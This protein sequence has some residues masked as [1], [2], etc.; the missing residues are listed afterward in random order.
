VTAILER[1]EKAIQ[2]L[3]TM[4]HEMGSLQ[5]W[6]QRF[7]DAIKECETLGAMLTDEMQRAYLTQNLNE[8]I[9]E[10]TRKSQDE[11]MLVS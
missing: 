3:K 11:A 6:L 4:K 7:D 9:F 1:Q 2:K 8:K 5:A 10:Q